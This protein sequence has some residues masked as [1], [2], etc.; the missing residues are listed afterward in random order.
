MKINIILPSNSWAGSFR[1][2][3]EHA[4][5]MAAWGESVEIYVPFFPYLDGASPLSRVG[6]G[7]LTWGLIRS[8]LRWNRVPWFN[9]KVPLKMVPFISDRFIRDAD[10]VM[11]NDWP[12]AY[13][14]ARLSASKGRKFHFIRDRECADPDVS[15]YSGR[16]N[17]SVN[18][19]IANLST[20]IGH[21]DVTKEQA[22]AW[23]EAVLKAD[24]AEKDKKL[25]ADQ[26]WVVGSYKLSL[27]KIV[28]APWLKDDLETNFGVK[29]CG[30]VQNGINMDD[31]GVPNKQY[32]DV[33]VICM[34]YYPVDVRKGMKDGLEVLTEVQRRYPSLKIVLFGWKRPKALPFKAEF[35]WRP[36][37]ERLRA[38]YGQSD[39]FLWT[40][41][42]EGF[43]NP[44]RE[45]MAAGC[46]VVATN[47][48]S[49][50]LSTIPGETALVVEPGD[51]NAMIESMCYLIENPE[52][53]RAIGRR[54]CEYIQQFS[55]ENATT[56]LLELFRKY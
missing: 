4:N 5:H 55:W 51:V 53:M 23:A 12:T 37:K 36:V 26:V 40:S 49:I 32:N 52:R 17:G 45:A 6:V 13:S 10:V 19:D 16:V 48:G 41:F 28:V 27:A 30:I 18:S 33:P 43:G 31:F 38:I 14:V 11:A 56:Q 20:D 34:H 21:E 22:I 15:G 1:S 3:Y 9:L 24:Q 50:P 42:R 2:T 44:P 39:I 54:G 7:L 35:H 47:V 46:A 25:V 8:L 29:V